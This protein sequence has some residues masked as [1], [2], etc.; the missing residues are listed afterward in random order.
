MKITK[1]ILAALF[2]IFLGFLAFVTLSGLAIVAVIVCKVY[3]WWVVLL[4]TLGGT[5]IV[6][7]II[8]RYWVTK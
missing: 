4:G 2:L 6:M 7:D 5:W 1:Y 8:V 3:P